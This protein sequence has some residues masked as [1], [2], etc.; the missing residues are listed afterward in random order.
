MQ[1]CHIKTEKYV[2]ILCLITLVSVNVNLFNMRIMGNVLGI[3]GT[4]VL[5]KW[6]I[7]L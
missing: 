4:F 1:L 5:E 3:I 6:R 2:I 7:A